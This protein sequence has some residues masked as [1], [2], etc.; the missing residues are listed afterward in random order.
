CASSSALWSLHRDAGQGRPSPGAPSTSSETK[1][2]HGR[3]GGELAVSTW[4]VDEGVRGCRA[5]D[6]VRLLAGDGL[7][8]ERVSVHPRPGAHELVALLVPPEADGKLPRLEA[9]Q[10]IRQA[11]QRPQ[12]GVDE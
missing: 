4:N 10:R 7:E 9:G 6:H 12:G 3:A 11:L 2:A 1:P 8:H 5:D